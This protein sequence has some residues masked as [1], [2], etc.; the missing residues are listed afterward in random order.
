MTGINLSTYVLR[1]LLSSE[2]EMKNSVCG[3]GGPQSG[4]M[5]HKTHLIGEGPSFQG[6]PGTI[7]LPPQV[8]WEGESTSRDR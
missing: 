3:A 6:S 1:H 7:P 8:S 2:K 5:L 4:E